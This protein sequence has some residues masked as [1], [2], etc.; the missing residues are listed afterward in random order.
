M[1]M[2]TGAIQVG[3]TTPPDQW[4]DLESMDGETD[5]NGY[6]EEPA[7][8]AWFI[9]K[10]PEWPSHL[11]SEATAGQ[12]A[13]INFGVSGGAAANQT[14]QAHW[15]VMGTPSLYGHA[16]ITGADPVV[17]GWELVSGT[18]VP[19]SQL[20]SDVFTLGGDAFALIRMTLKL[21]YVTAADTAYVNGCMISTSFGDYAGNP[22]VVTP[23][24]TNNRIFTPNH[25]A[26]AYLGAAILC[27]TINAY[28]AESTLYFSCPIFGCTA[29]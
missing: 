25:F 28:V 12:T 3:G 23:R 7:M 1:A 5:T 15:T 11:L 14:I 13:Q 22:G 8:Y 4:Y 27:D 2:P 18:S 24:T 10:L 9:V 16:K 29:A 26:D 19:V 20:N 6:D 21:S 17:T